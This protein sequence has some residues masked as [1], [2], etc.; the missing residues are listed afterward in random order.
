MILAILGTAQLMVVLDATVVNI[1]LPS[2]QKTLHF[3]TDNRQW[4]I[5]AYALAFGSL[6][7][8]GGRLSDWFGRKWTLIAGLAGFALASAAGGA[9]Q[10]FAVLV[11]ERALQG[12]FG[13]MLAPAALSLLTTTFT[14][15][16]ERA[17]AFGIFAAIAG[18]GASIG[19]LL[20]GVLTQALSWRYCMYV[21]LLFATA[22]GVGAMMLVGNSRPRTRPRLDIPGAVAV[23]SGLF[24]LVYGFAHAQTTRWGDSL[25]I[26]VLAA[27]VSLLAMFVVL[28]GRVTT[29]LLPL[30]VLASRNRGASFLSIGIAGGA[31]FAVILYLTYYLQQTRG[32]SPITTGLAFLPMTATIMGAAILGLTRLQQRFGPRALIAVG[33][34]L[35]TLGTLYLTQIRLGSGYAGGILPGLVV[36]GAG[37]GLVFSTS[38]ANATL[39]VEPS[40]S[41]VASATV[42]ASQ[43]VGGSVGVALLS[44]IAASASAHYLAGGHHVAEPVA[45][46]AVHGY[47]VGFGW[48]SGI[49]AVSAVVCAALFTPR[50]R[51][52]DRGLDRG[53]GKLASRHRVVVVGGGFGGLQAALKLARLPVDVTLIDRRNFHFFQPLAYQVAT[54]ALSAAEISYPLR[55]VF[56]RRHNVRVLLAEVTDVDLDAERVTVRPTAGERCD[57]SVTFDTLIVAAGSQYNYFHRDEWRQVAP[58]LKTVESALEIRAR[59]LRAFEAAELESDPARR[60]A[61]LTFVV[62]GAGPTGV[63]M[64]GQIAEIARDLRADFQSLDASQARILLV[65][66]GD[67]VLGALPPTLSAK[68]QRSLARL[69][70]TTLLEHMVLEL[71]ARSVTVERPRHPSEQIPA[72][73]V[74][75]AAGVIAS[76]LAG[77]LADRAG[78]EVDRAGRVEVLEDLSLPGHPNVLAIGDMIRIRRADGSFS[79]LPGLAPVAMQEGRHAARVVRDRLRGRSG[80]RFRYHDKGNLATIGRARAVAEVKHVR[81]SGFLAWSTWL[82]VHLWYLVG[83][84]NR[85][86]VLTRWAFSFVA[87]GRGARLITDA[88]R[89]P[90]AGADHELTSTDWRSHAIATASTHATTP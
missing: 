83:F 36:I 5:T 6:L 64:A 54:G 51:G 65:E 10:S 48:A 79:A 16:A 77:V 2:A 88:A 40:D 71:D 84:E 17:K 52:L 86:L 47:A 18:S 38:I 62:V 12:A 25:T 41:G 45:H 22:A 57:G 82:T 3:S 42:N 27:G 43:Q 81:M 30:R 72:R 37:L 60:A 80:R 14:D 23:S 1:A 15:P 58:D 4:I 67:R 49:F 63:E 44:T 85:L 26:G 35:G 70:V 89:R 78:L 61:W 75:W 29:P 55:R 19:L 46:A 24:A 76:S 11:A 39:G 87:H 90:T 74:V 32:F 59:I 56:R 8:L 33:M 68:A 73:T 50:R 69:G 53:E 34:T 20:G 13:A 28:E 7:L 21:N 9:A 66:A 31:I